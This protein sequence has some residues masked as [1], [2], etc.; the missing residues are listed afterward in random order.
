M[1]KNMQKH[2]PEGF[3]NFD[4]YP[5][6]AYVE[7]EVF[8]LLTN[9]SRTSTWRG[10]KKGTLPQPIK[11]GERKLAFNVGEIRNFLKQTKGVIQ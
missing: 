6:S 1:E 7:Y 8:M 10:V 2:L 4:Q 9:L 11:F 3:V 5:D